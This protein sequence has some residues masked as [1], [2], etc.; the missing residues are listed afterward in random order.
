MLES[1]HPINIAPMKNPGD[2]FNREWREA[3]DRVRRAEEKVHKAWTEYAAG[4][5]GAPPT[6]LLEEV[7]RLRRE[8][9]AEL[10]KLLANIQISRRG[11][12]RPES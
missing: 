10:S 3:N 1:A 5:A 11:P 7:S 2:E 4:R 6:E 8:S 12:E 9:D